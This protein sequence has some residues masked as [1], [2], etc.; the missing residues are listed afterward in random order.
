M[1]V[2]NQLTSLRYD[3]L[4]QVKDLIP[5]RTKTCLLHSYVI[6]GSISNLTPMEHKQNQKFKEHATKNK[7]IMIIV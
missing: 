3:I 5:N 6:I 4:P 1:I 2:N 7:T